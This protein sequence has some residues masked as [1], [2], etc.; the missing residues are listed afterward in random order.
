M[1]P[2]PIDMRDC[3]VYSKSML[4]LPL[5]ALFACT[6]DTSSGDSGLLNLDPATVALGGACALDVDFGGFQVL[7]AESGSGVDGN[8]ADGVVPQ[9][10]LEEIATGGDCRLLRRNNPFC[11]PTCAAGETCDFDGE[12]L[13]Y[14]SKQDLGTVTI[15]GLVQSVS[16]EA[17]FPG[18]TYYDSTVPTPPFE[19]GKL[20][21]MDM[22]GGAYGPL[23]LYG[24]GV[25]PLVSI[26]AEWSVESGVDL[27][28]YWEPPTGAVVRSEVGM[29][30][31]VDQH[32]T[33]PGA[34][35]CTFADTGEGTVPFSVIDKLVSAGVTGF[36]SGS[37][38]RRTI[39][40]GSAGDDCM[41][42]KVVAPLVVDVDVIGFT[43]CISDSDC[44]DDLDCNVEL[45]VC[46]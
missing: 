1:A 34:L 25:E 2:R 33:S 37:L 4:T 11:D 23:T 41:D 29:S 28:V 12:C 10:V 20:I 9:L 3:V 8:V 46:Q 31:N 21:A 40:H 22:P 6:D 5:I 26:D 14:P 43:P 19:P 30:I 27:V 44:P 13:P 16:M 24:V 36:P 45:Q 42:F 15:A 35:Y 17:V 32:G 38:E 7:S 18:N 39:D